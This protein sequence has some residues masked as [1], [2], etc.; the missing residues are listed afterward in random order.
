MN[1]TKILLSQTSMIIENMHHNYY[2]HSFYIHNGR[3]TEVQIHAF[4]NSATD[5][6][7][8]LTSRTVHLPNPSTHL[9]SLGGPQ[10]QSGRFE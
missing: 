7:V 3:R 2:K 6:V 9:R 4:L 5:V 8:C 1:V 10:N